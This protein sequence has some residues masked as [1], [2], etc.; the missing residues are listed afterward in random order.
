VIHLVGDANGL[1]RQGQRGP[2]CASHRPQHRQVRQRVGLVAPIA[3]RPVQLQRR[4]EQLESGFCAAHQPVGLAEIGQRDRP[5][6]RVVVQLNPL[7][8]VV[9]RHRELAL[10]QANDTEVRQRGRLTSRPTGLAVFGERPPEVVGATLQVA[11]LAPDHAEVA[12][13]RGLR[14]RPT[15]PPGLCQRLLVVGGGLVVPTLTPI[16]QAEADQCRSLRRGI[17]FCPCGG[18]PSLGSD[19][20][21]GGMHPVGEVAAQRIGEPPSHRL[22]TVFGG[23][24]DGRNEIGPLGVEP[25]QRLLLVVVAGSGSV[26]SGQ[27]EHVRVQH[28]RRPVRHLQVV[29]EQSGHGLPS[30]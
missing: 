24:Y 7:T 2:V 14:L 25:R 22:W 8:E 5:R 21:V 30:V 29:I 12:V 1:G 13:D 19:Q 6:V 9:G 3:G 28:V 18:Q 20:P 10:L 27:P 11:G 16:K 4:G 15:S 17:T 23:V 26:Q